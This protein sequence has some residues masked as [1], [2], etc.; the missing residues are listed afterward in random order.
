MGQRITFN[1]P[2]LGEG[3]TEGE[4]AAWLVEPGGEVKLNQPFVE[5]ETAKALVEVPSPYDGVLAEHHAAAGETVDVG[6]PLASF[7]VEGAVTP[8]PE[9]KKDERTPNLVGYGAREA[10]SKRRK[11]RTG[12][13]PEAPAAAAP[14]PVATPAPAAPAPVAAAAPAATSGPVLAK[15]PVRKL[16]KDLGIDLATLVP[17]GPNGTVSRAD[18]QAA[19]SAPAAAAPAKITAAAEDQRIPIKGVR[20]LTAQNMVASAFT[21]P[22]ATVFL[23]CDVTGMMDTVKEFKGRKEFADVKVTPLLFVAKA[24]LLA[25]RRHPMINAQWDEAAQEIVVKHDV[26]LGIAAATPRGLVVPNVKAAQDLSLVELAE[27][28]TALARTAREGKTSPADMSGGTISITNVG[29]FGIDTGTPILPPGESAILVFG[30]VRPQPWVHEGEIAVRQVT[31]LGLSF[32]HRLIDGE[33]G[34]QFLAD[35]GSFLQH[36]GETLLAWT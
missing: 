19:V 16:A 28:L 33:L 5:V 12:D 15:P 3:L 23:T 17:T 34:S 11:R 9:K 24:V 32:D 35:V 10:G 7:E 25:A 13:A 29:V 20:K 6:K 30:A 22:H 18:V 26:N 8:P 36:P 31:T 14:A 27:A 2:D 1:L 4:V 21:A